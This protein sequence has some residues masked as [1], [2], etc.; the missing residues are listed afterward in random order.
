[1]LAQQGDLCQQRIT[2]IGPRVR[3]EPAHLLV[4][5]SAD[6]EDPF[7]PRTRV[8]TVGHQLHLAHQT[9]G[10]I[11]QIFQVVGAL[12]ARQMLHHHPF[13]AC[14]DVGQLEQHHRR[15]RAPEQQQH[16]QHHGQT[17]ADRGAFDHRFP[18]QM[19]ASRALRPKAPPDGSG[20]R[21]RDSGSLDSDRKQIAA[22]QTTRHH[23]PPAATEH[24]HR[25][26]R[27]ISRGE[28]R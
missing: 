3:F 21:V 22:S 12:Q 24:L 9:R 4:R 13:S 27:H 8:R 10:V 16:N 26:I 17:G 19:H 15:H 6:A 14:V 25:F 23:A 2:V 5:A 18:A 11:G 7:D 1:V 20:V 28:T